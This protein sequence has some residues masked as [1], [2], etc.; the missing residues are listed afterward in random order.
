MPI[1]ANVVD[2]LWRMMQIHSLA[3]R[4]AFTNG[5]TP[6]AAAGRIGSLRQAMEFMQAVGSSREGCPEQLTALV[7][8]AEVIADYAKRNFKSRDIGPLIAIAEMMQK[9]TT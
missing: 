5:H 9:E 8:A 7:E 4:G 2:S 1:T 6:S 3:K